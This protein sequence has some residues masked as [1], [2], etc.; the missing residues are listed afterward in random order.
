M[1]KH[2]KFFFYQKS[3]NYSI[4]IKIFGTYLIKDGVF[5]LKFPNFVDSIF[6]VLTPAPLN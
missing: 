4:L 5:Y 2:M 3:T 6:L 1:K